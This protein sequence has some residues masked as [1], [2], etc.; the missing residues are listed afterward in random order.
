MQKR[1]IEINYLIN[2]AG[3]GGQGYFHE[4]PWQKDHDMIM[5][6]IMALTALTRLFL[7]TMIARNEG[8]ILHVASSARLVPGPLQA[9]YYATKAYVLSFSQ[10]LAGELM[11]TP[12]TV[13]ALA[14]GA[15]A[16]EFSNTADLE[17]TKLFSGKMFSADEVARDGY[18]A[19]LD[20]T[21]VKLSALS[22]FQKINLKL[23][24]LVPTKMVL[25]QVKDLQQVGK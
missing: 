25:K 8:R 12:I 5:V 15:T 11:D 19:M 10:G 16:T 4:R 18:Q 24:P 9:V 13:T 14:P 21:L 2:N 3:F 7:P 22:I 20:G 1:N 23:A 6:N 17:K